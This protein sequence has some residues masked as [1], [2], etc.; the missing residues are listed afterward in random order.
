MHLL[1]YKTLYDSTFLLFIYIKNLNPREVLNLFLMQSNFELAQFRPHLS[2]LRM[3]I[4]EML[5]WF[6]KA[7]LLV[8]LAST[9]ML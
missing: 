6:G 1:S 7:R 4:W 8:S 2:L 3:S 5:P 9:L